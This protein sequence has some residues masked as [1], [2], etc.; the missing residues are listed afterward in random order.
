MIIPVIYVKVIPEQMAEVN[1]LYETVLF[2]T[3]LLQWNRMK[4][5]TMIVKIVRFLRHYQNE[6]FLIVLF[7]PYKHNITLHTSNA[8]SRH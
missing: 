3:A 1:P 8:T 7:S 4:Y 5:Y 2:W 6:E